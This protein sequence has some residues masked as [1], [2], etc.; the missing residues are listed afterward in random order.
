MT[1]TANV[2]QQQQQQQQTSSSLAPRDA[3]FDRTQS[4]QRRESLCLFLH[5]ALERLQTPGHNAQTRVSRHL[6]DH[7]ACSLR[8][9]WQAGPCLSASLPTRPYRQRGGQQSALRLPVGYWL[10]SFVLLRLRCSGLLNTRAHFDLRSRMLRLMLKIG[11]E[12]WKTT[13]ITRIILSS[14]AIRNQGLI[15][16]CIPSSDMCNS[17]FRAGTRARKMSYTSVQADWLLL[18]NGFSIRVYPSSKHF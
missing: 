14:A 11:L 1:I 8:V 2:Q 13:S 17:G 10:N 5:Q 7:T 6:L 3:E 4:S 16:R 12:S 18:Y 9:L 15:T